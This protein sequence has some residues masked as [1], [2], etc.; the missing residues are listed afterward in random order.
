MSPPGTRSPPAPAPH[1]GTAPVF[2][3]TATRETE[4]G[5]GPP[6]GSPPDPRYRLRHRPRGRLPF[7]GT[8]TDPRCCPR[9]RPDILGITPRFLGS[10]LAPPPGLLPNPRD[11]PGSASESP[12]DLRDGPLHHPRSRFHSPVSPWKPGIVAGIPPRFPG[13]PRDQPQIPGTSPDRRHLPRIARGAASPFPVPPWTSSTVPGIAPRSP[14]S[15]SDARCRPPITPSAASP[16]PVPP[17]CRYQGSAP[18]SPLDHRY[19]P[20]IALE[21]A[22]RPPYTTDHWYRPRDHPQTEPSVPPPW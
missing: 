15:P 11:R 2:F 6:L 17:G 12:P 7:P 22:S 13:S 5:S 8:A 21:A 9:D 19:C 1:R 4:T 3:G 14:A 18:G 16:S 20:G 10:T